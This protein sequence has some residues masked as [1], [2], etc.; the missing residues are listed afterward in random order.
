VNARLTR[1]LAIATS[2]LGYVVII[3]WIFNVGLLKSLG[4][5]FPPMKMLTAVTLAIAALALVLNDATQARWIARAAALVVLAVGALSLAEWIAH[6]DVGIDRWLAYDTSTEVPGRM[7]PSTAASFVLIGI[8]LLTLDRAASKFAAIGVLLIGYLGVIGFAFEA[9]TVDGLGW[10]TRLVPHTAIAQVALACG[11]LAARRAHGLIAIVTQ[12]SSAGAA[13]R[14]LLPV[15][16]LLPPV[17]GWLCLHGQITGT[18]GAEAAIS[19]MASVSATLLIGLVIWNA[20]VQGRNELARAVDAAD[21][22]L[23]FAL[24]ENM[25]VTHDGAAIFTS[26]CERLG[27]H[28]G[29]ERCYFIDID[30]A[31]DRMSIA[32]DFHHNV[33]SMVGTY[34]VSSFTTNISGDEKPACIVNRDT[35]TDPRTAAHFARSFGPVQL[36]AYVSTPYVRD[37]KWVGSLVAGSSSPRV[38]LDR[39][40][41]LLN[42]ISERIWLWV[43][44]VRMVAELHTI[45]ADLEDRVRSRTAELS[46]TLREREVLLQEIH[47]RVKNNLQVISSLINMQVRRLEPGVTHDALQECQTRVLAIALIHEQLYQSSDYS[48]VQF[49]NYTR[50]LAANVFHATG[51]SQQRVKLELAIDDVPLGI[52][53]AIPCGLVINEL[54]TNALR[55]GFNGDRAGT[56]RVELSKLVD[57]R[58]RLTVRDDGVGLPP[59]FDI[60]A[61]RSMGLQLV[62]TLSEQLDA[63]LVVD[64]AHGASFELT[65]EGSG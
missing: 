10:A 21:D 14:R 16:A 45:N 13:V 6:I 3:G 15:V 24:T 36:E 34:A 29:L 17:V 59:G 19:I 7:G 8:A 39:E 9:P 53:R 5:W 51:I 56:I 46:G 32:Q 4:P 43:E 41:K 50:S 11:L 1:S 64:G 30:V 27:K 54:I 61:L 18:Y 48:H 35:K 20:S 25:H 65:F 57:A 26:T 60:R 22:K 63:T 23:L 12:R 55:H 33:S 58:V 49:A 38:W 37:G 2:V 47:H 28:L 62:T 40:V 42:T 44:H 31:N 52:D